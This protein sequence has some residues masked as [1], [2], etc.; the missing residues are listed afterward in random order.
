MR[1]VCE[2]VAEARRDRAGRGALLDE[3]AA[4]F[5]V[6][7][8]AHREAVAEPHE[9]AG[10]QEAGELGVLDPH[11]QE[12]GL[13]ELVSSCSA[14]SARSPSAAVA[15]RRVRLGAPALDGEERE[16]RRRPRAPREQLGDGHTGISGETAAR[17]SSARTTS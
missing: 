1:P 4:G 16:E 12:A 8:G 6:R 10:L 13:V 2:E 14:A 17:S 5:L 3:Q 15:P 9:A 11:R 7:R